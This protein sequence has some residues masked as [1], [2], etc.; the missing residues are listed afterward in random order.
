MEVIM[1]ITLELEYQVF[2]SLSSSLGR[3]IVALNYLNRFYLHVRISRPRAFEARL[4]THASGESC[5]KVVT[6]SS[7][8]VKKDRRVR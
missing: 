7:L 6:P 2:G 3:I 5:H 8:S 4:C 1:Q